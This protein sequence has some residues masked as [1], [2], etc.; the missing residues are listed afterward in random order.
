MGRAKWVEI[1]HLCWGFRFL[2]PFKPQVADKP[3][4]STAM[5]LVPACADPRA[6][7]QTSPCLTWATAALS[8]H[9]HTPTWHEQTWAIAASSGRLQRFIFTPQNW[10]DLG[11]ISKK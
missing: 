5:L 4:T 6:T 3:S 9:L 2:M 10:Q 11:E 7:L 8:S 1:L